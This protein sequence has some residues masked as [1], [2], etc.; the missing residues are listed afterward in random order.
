MNQNEESK[1]EN[2]ISPFLI[3]SLTDNR[4]QTHFCQNLIANL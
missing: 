1:D 2:S 3:N 4:G